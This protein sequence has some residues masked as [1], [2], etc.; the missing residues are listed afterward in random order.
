MIASTT[1]R[2]IGKVKSEILFFT[3]LICTTLAFSQPNSVTE[4]DVIK[5]ANE[6][7][8][9]EDYQ[10]ALP[11][12]AQ[13]VS[14]HPAEAEYNYRFG[15][16]TLFGDRHDKKKPIRYLSN[17]AKSMKDDQMLVYYLGLAY[18]QN[19]EYATAMRHF[20]MYLA[21]LSPNS[22]ERASI[23]EK[24]YACLNGLNLSHKR[25][26]ADV[27][28]ESEFQKDNFHRAYRAD[29]LDGSLVIKPEIF[30]TS[31]EKKH[32]ELSFVYMSEPRCALLCWL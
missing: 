18:H 8:S 16:C 23:L 3:F 20:N 31:K 11:L 15:V 28:S 24:V 5:Q 10:G 25:L 12:Y 26:I 6:L 30:Q 29:Q 32:G 17:A 19:E 27:V 7:F 14:V 1:Y 21:K 22:T 4:E 13:L 9:N 2:N